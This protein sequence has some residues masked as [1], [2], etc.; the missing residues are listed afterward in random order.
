MSFTFFVIT[1]LRSSGKFNDA[2]FL[3][4]FFFAFDHESLNP[5][6]RLKISAP[7][8]LPLSAQK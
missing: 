5:T 4:L 8:P 3:Q 1:E 6:V 7:G 2:S